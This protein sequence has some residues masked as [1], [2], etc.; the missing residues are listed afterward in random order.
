MYSSE[1]SHINF[2][3]SL[4]F[5]S[6]NYWFSYT[7]KNI[8]EWNTRKS[9]SDKWCLSIHRVFRRNT[10]NKES[11][12]VLFF[13]EYVAVH[14]LASFRELCAIC[15]C[16]SS[17]LLNGGWSRKIRTLW[18]GGVDPFVRRDGVWLLLSSDCPFVHRT[19]FF[20]FHSFPPHAFTFQPIYVWALYPRFIR[21]TPNF[22]IK[23]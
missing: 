1:S 12:A 21:D 11:L 20:H 22:K 4:Y 6:Q 17:S 7:P 8:S 18:V 10:R 9:S 14:L 2:L 5:Y 19:S 3:P 15:A 23:R 16:E 13:L